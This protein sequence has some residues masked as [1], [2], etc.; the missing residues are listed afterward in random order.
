MS[1]FARFSILTKILTVIAVMTCMVCGGVWFAVSRMAQIDE[2]Y[3]RFL[4]NEV[5]ASAAAPRLNRAIVH[6]QMLSYRIVAETNGVELFKLRPQFDVAIAD[7]NKFAQEIV[8]YAP[9]LAQ[10]VATIEADIQQLKGAVAPVIDL[11]IK[12][13]K[14]RA[15]DLL[16]KRVDVVVEK[17][18]AASEAMRERLNGEI[19][20]GSDGLHER[21]VTTTRTTWIVI[22]VIMAIAA[23]FAFI[24][25]TF[26]ISTPIR[27]LGALLEKLAKGEEAEI[28]GT[29]RKDEIG[30]IARAVNGIRL[31]LAEKGRR[32]AEEK[33]VTEQAAS[34]QRRAEMHKL[35]E[36]FEAAVGSIVNAVSTSAGELETAANTLTGTADNTQRL[37][38]M[39]ASASEQA[40]SN[41]QT[42]ASA[43]DEM[44]A[45]VSEIG[46][47][48]HESS[49]IAGEAVKQAERTDARITELSQ[50]AQRIGDVVQLITEIAEQTNLLALNATIEAARAG[51]AGRG[52]AV[53]ASEV[54]ALA[55]Q[56][57]KATGE[58]GSQI[59]SMQTA[60]QDSVAAIKEI[61]GTIR[62]ISDIAAAIAAAVEEQSAA[63]QEISRNVQQAAQG[64]IQ[65][66]DNISEVSDGA[67]A[68]GAASSKVLTAAQQLSG[69][70]RTL[71]AE[72]DRFLA[73]VRAA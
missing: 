62:H 30:M 59:A 41:V 10:E 18:L 48:V 34:E 2:G 57:A 43:S 54:K 22:G 12:D 70:G 64:T 60:T 5:M 45:S 24:V 56:T 3:S 16:H 52:F 65:V 9:A 44:A 53:V 1:I 55:A 38:T 27:N 17:V 51:E 20:S 4:D 31:M 37:S 36:D 68:T 11:A 35:A 47:Q 13:D 19:K 46:R 26:G 49:T 29:D 21:S 14:D 40:S 50:A 6:F 39:V 72:V 28:T 67:N 71:R 8:Q 15:L 61:N 7:A 58:I 69:Q 73:T 32:E 33:M 42:V 23:A 66:A 63:T 25:A